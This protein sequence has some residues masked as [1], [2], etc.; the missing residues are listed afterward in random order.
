MNTFKLEIVT[1]TKIL[2]ED[3]VSYIRCPGL[4]GLFGV[5]A[6]HTESIFALDIGE[7]KLTKN[8]KDQFF[9]TSG[10]FAEVMGEEVHL[11][12]ET[13]EK[14]DVIDSDRAKSAVERAEDRL[15]SEEEIAYL[16]ARTSLSRAVNRLK[17]SSK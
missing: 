17:I 13:V 16:R 11:L 8:N 5:M 7:I 9:A 15:K 3:E 10:G 12:L 6:G 4:D 2:E 14:S 1:P